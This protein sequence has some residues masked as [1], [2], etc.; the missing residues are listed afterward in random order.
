MMKIKNG[1]REVFVV[2]VPLYAEA[3]GYVL[4]DKCPNLYR[5]ADTTDNPTLQIRAYDKIEQRVDEMLFDYRNHIGSPH[6][7]ASFKRIYGVTP[8]WVE[9][10]IGEARERYALILGQAGIANFSPRFVFTEREPKNGVIVLGRGRALS[11]APG[12]IMVSLDNQIVAQGIDV[13][14]IRGHRT[15][16]ERE[17]MKQLLQLAVVGGNVRASLEFLSQ[18][19]ARLNEELIPRESLVYSFRAR[20]DYRHYSIKSRQERTNVIRRYRM[21]QGEKK[22]Y[23]LLLIDGLPAE[24]DKESF[25]S[26]EYKHAPIAAEEYQNRIFARGRTAEVI[27][28]LFADDR[29][30]PELDSILMGKGTEADIE[31]VLAKLSQQTNLF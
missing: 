2:Y 24:V 25:L 9:S 26:P 19:A 27:N 23:G 22:G 20:L 5:I 7:E 12:S 29:R 13:Y 3:L 8:W 6:N 28:A 15:E 1:L 10:R 21:K 18:E 31:A 11:I 16:F 30:P 4:Q 14:F 17:L